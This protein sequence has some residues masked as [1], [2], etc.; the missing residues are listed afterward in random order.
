MQKRQL[1]MCLNIQK[2]RNVVSP[3]ANQGVLKGL[4]FFWSETE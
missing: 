1:M 3:K 4:L 2:H